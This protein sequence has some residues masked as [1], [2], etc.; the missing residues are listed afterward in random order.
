MIFPTNLHGIR[1]VRGLNKNKHGLSLPGQQ[2]CITRR[3][4]LES[5]LRR[6]TLSSVGQGFSSS[7]SSH[8]TSSLRGLGEKS[9][10]SGH[11]P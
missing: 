9:E 7:A 4:L 2:V 10:V 1:G 5:Q 6:G 11:P 3:E 8:F